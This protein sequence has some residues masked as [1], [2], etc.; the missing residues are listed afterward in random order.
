MLFFQ[1]LNRI[2]NCGQVSNEFAIEEETKLNEND[3]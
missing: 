3:E 2:L 1:Y